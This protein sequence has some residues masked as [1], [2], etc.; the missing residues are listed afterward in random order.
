[1]LVVPP[2]FLSQKD[3]LLRALP[4][5]M[6]LP[7][8]TEAAGSPL[9]QRASHQAQFRFSAVQGFHDPL[10]A[11]TALPKVLLPGSTILRFYSIGIFLR[12]QPGGVDK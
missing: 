11:F 5:D 1:M 9:A 12:G 8:I 3:R 10:L 4:K 7:M 2:L 6:R